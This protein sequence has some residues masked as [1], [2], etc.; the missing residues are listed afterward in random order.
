MKTNR[1]LLRPLQLTSILFIAA[2]LSGCATNEKAILST[3]GSIVTPPANS[4]AAHEALQLQGH[5]YVPG[6]ESPAEGFDCSGLVF[7][8][9]GKQ[10]LKLPRDTWS[11]ANQL[12][13]VQL[14]L[15]QPGDLLFFNIDT[16]PFAHVG[17][18]VGQ[19]KFVHAPST[20]TGKVMMSDLN[21][22]YWR[23]RFSAVRRPAFHQPLSLNEPGSN[24]CLLN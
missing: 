21:K 20:R 6:G 24:A 17:I 3:P 5:P 1:P 18:Y 8:V 10:G 2:Q 4:Q 11:L 22:P 16:K 23:E 7:Y 14:H 13:S 12:P 15:R 9:Y 19:D